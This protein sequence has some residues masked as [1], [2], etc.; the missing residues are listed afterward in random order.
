MKRL[1]LATFVVISLVFTSAVSSCS[2][3]VAQAQYDKLYDEVNILRGKKA[4][5]SMYALFLDIL[6]YQF[7]KQANVPSRYQFASYDD[8]TQSLTKTAASMNDAKLTSLLNK[9]IKDPETFMEIANYV[10]G[11]I[12]TTLQS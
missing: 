12:S 4:E 7:Y 11:K 8:W 10:I 1:F 3:G 6:M 2:S 9:M 5:A